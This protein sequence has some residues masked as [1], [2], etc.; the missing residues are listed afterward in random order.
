MKYIDALKKYNEGKDRWCSPKK[1]SVDYLRIRSMMKQDTKTSSHSFR[2]KSSPVNAPRSCDYEIVEDN[3]EIYLINAV[4][5]GDCFINAIF[6]YCLYTGKLEAIYNRLMR[7]ELLIMSIAKYEDGVKKTKALFKGFSIKKH[8]SNATDTISSLTKINAKD[9]PSEY[10]K[11]SKRLTYFT[12]QKKSS[13]SVAYDKERKAFSKTM[14]YIQVLYIYTYGN[15][16]FLN[17]LMRYMEIAIYAKSIEALDWD[18]SL[19]NYVK[20]K[21]YHK[22]TGNLKATIDIHK[23]LDEYMRIYA[24]TN[25]YFTGDDQIFIFRKILFKRM[26]GIPQFWLN[27]ET[28]Q[29]VSNLTKIIKFRKMSGTDA[30]N[31]FVEKDG[32]AYNYISLLRDGEHY[33][34]FVAKSSVSNVKNKKQKGGWDKEDADFVKYYEETLG[35]D[36]Q[37]LGLFEKKILKDLLLN[38]NDVYKQE[39]KK[40]EYALTYIRG[41]DNDDSRLIDDYNY[42]FPKFSIV[43]KGTIFYRR[44]KTETKPNRQVWLDY[45]GTMSSIPFSFLQETNEKYTVE[46]LNRTKEHFGNFLMKFKVKKDLLIL[47]FPSYATS[48]LESWVKY[49]CVVS[50]NKM[51]VDGYTLDFLK[52]NPNEIY[53]DLNIVEGVRELCILNAENVSLVSVKPKNKHTNKNKT[54]KLINQRRR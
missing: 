7:V 35:K 10:R 18:A 25:G 36:M 6:D 29:S 2:S 12:H 22:K 30:T 51:C 17:R 47:H 3:P 52:F 46:H 23:L 50:E 37:N 48:Y 5:D 14:K 27:Y 26:K 28:I 42:D 33:L 43:P 16:V 45:T 53:K 1:G 4:G 8:V 40:I 20:N 15:K 13:G 9:V 31:K 24:E 19:I 34:L 54:G 49:M 38:I 21:Y 44:Q 11:L 32:N 41:L 39:F